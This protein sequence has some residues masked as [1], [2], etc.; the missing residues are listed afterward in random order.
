MEKEIRWINKWENDSNLLLKMIWKDVK[1]KSK[2]MLCYQILKTSF[3]VIRLHHKFFAQAFLMVQINKTHL[4]FSLTITFLWLLFLVE[5][6]WE[7]KNA[8][9]FA[10]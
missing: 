3:E 4:D 6:L 1:K 9:I 7:E 8:L 5:R 2:Q 10:L